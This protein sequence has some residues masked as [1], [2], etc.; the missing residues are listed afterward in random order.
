MSFLSVFAA[1]A[2]QTSPFKEFFVDFYHQYIV[3]DVHYENLNFGSGSFLSVRMIVV[4]LFIGIALAGFAAV[5]NKR[6]LGSF[7]RRLIAQEC[8]SPDSAKTLDELGFGA[9]IFIR[10]AMRTS[11]VNL[12]RVVKCREE[13]L[14]YEQL[15][16]ER[17][18]YE[19]ERE[20]DPKLPKFEETPYR[21]D[22]LEDSFYIP[23]DKKYVADMKFAANGTSWLG[24]IA[25]FVVSFI[26]LVL[27]LVAL[28]SILGLIDDFVGG[29]K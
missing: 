22:V 5:F 12:R 25:L 18:A 19:L 6:V 14:Y 13:E 23:E 2:Q 11:G 1:A 27:V 26:A 9:N 10:F 3:P 20:K 29:F 15:A 17:E 16:K 7:V 28:P 24:I 21:V 8:L 4:G